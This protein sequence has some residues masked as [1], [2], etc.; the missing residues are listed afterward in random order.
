[1]STCPAAT[2]V[3]YC[4]RSPNE[5]HRCELPDDHPHDAIW[6][7]VTRRVVHECGCGS[8]WTCLTGSVDDLINLVAPRPEK[9]GA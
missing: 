8:R 5:A 7:D 6:G 9:Q 4:A 2:G 3:A 1:M